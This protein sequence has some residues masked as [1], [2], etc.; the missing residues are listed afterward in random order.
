MVKSISVAEELFSFPLLRSNMKFVRVLKGIAGSLV[1]H[2]LALGI[3]L[4]VAVQIGQP[5]VIPES[6]TFRWEVT[7]ASSP[8]LEAVTSDVPSS[9]LSAPSLSSPV[10]PPQKMDHSTRP[11]SSNSPVT[12]LHEPRNNTPT[13]LSAESNMIEGFLSKRPIENGR[14]GPRLLPTSLKSTASNIRQAQEKTD[15]MPFTQGRESNLP[16][17]VEN[18]VDRSEQ[19]TQPSIVEEPRVLQRP[20]PFHRQVRWLDTRP[21]YG[22]LIHDLKEKFDRLKF[23]PKTARM[24]KWEGK[25]VVQMK[26]LA[27]GYLIDAAV[28]ESSGFDVLDQAALAIIREASPLELE[29]PLLASNVMLSVPLT[30]RLE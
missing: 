18:V 24:N 27:D 20:R 2:T 23:Y 5:K 11:S 19:V 29:N 1:F 26:I 8:L 15:E 9:F 12:K 16:P 25:V 6:S 3:G 10:P 4:S 13:E 22:W 30:F 28:E 14:K 7:L 17:P 21:D